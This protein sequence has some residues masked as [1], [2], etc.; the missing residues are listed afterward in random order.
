MS[1]LLASGDS[2]TDFNFISCIVPKYDQL[3]SRWPDLLGK[4]IGI[5]E[6]V[7]VGK[8]GASNTFIFNKCYD[9]IS[10]RK[11]KLVCVLITD[12]SRHSVFDS[13]FCDVVNLISTEYIASMGQF[14][15]GISSLSDWLDGDEI[16]LAMAKWLWANELSV[17][18]I[19]NNN[20]REIWLFQNFCQHNN[21]NYIIMSAMDPV[22]VQQLHFLN[23][24]SANDQ[25]I[26]DL[27]NYIKEILKS[28]HTDK[29][30]KGTLLG[31]PFF[32]E[33]GGYSVS[34]NLW[35]SANEKNQKVY[36]HQEGDNH[37][38]GLGHQI[39]ADMFY[40]GYQDIYG[41]IS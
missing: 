35:D 39:I 8:S 10:K 12:W 11:P 40:K 32:K 17:K 28:P 14:P 34:S 24:Y 30:D 21:I 2:F 31:W 5:S 6:V 18:D 33:I 3:F 23:K 36:I 20:M 22:R 13:Y 27:S 37:P 15:P 4:Q 26:A 1:Y 41:K 25:G 9:E 19:V 7:N 16:P 29:L 38:N